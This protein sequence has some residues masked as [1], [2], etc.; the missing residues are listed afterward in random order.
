MTFTTT[1]IWIARI[2]RDRIWF[3]ITKFFSGLNFRNW[4]CFRN[5]VLLNNFTLFYINKYY[6]WNF[7]FYSFSRFAIQ[8]F[9]I[10]L[11]F[12]R[13]F[14]NFQLHWMLNIRSFI[15]CPFLDRWFLNIFI[16][17]WLFLMLFIFLFY[18]LRRFLYFL[19]RHR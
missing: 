10:F 12:R 19:Y 1:K 18:Y 15:F 13:L 16:N 14:R 3:A 9:S 11:F 7:E 2:R 8:R 17:G 6:F 4:Q 5:K